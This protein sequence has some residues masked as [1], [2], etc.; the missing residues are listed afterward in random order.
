[1]GERGRE[2]PRSSADDRGISP[3][4]RFADSIGKLHIS[5]LGYANGTCGCSYT[6]RSVEYGGYG[7]HALLTPSWN[8]GV[9]EAAHQPAGIALVTALPQRRCGGCTAWAHMSAASGG[10]F[11]D[12]HAEWVIWVATAVAGQAS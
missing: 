6:S 3:M 7:A 4:W 12:E 5:C 2:V 10:S 11:A 1:M 9:P 8:A